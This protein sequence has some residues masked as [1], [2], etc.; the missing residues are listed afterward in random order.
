MVTAPGS[1]DRLLTAGFEPVCLLLYT[2]V[3]W[4]QRLLTSYQSRR[5]D[6]TVLCYDAP[7]VP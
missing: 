1:T 6:C 7:G 5:S 2:P 3:S 4:V